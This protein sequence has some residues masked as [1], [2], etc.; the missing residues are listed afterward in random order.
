[1]PLIVISSQRARVRSI[2]EGPITDISTFFNSL[3]AGNFLMLLLLSADF[4]QNLHFQRNLSRTQSECHMVWLQI[5]D[6]AK[7]G[8]PFVKKCLNVLP[9][10][11][12]VNVNA[13]VVVTTSWWLHFSAQV[14]A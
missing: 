1:M 9:I 7:C 13:P 12:L 11:T 10:I 2:D 3:N 6:C 5:S 8:P 14:V 4:F